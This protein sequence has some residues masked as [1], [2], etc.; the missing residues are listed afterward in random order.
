[1]TGGTP[2]AFTEL[3]QTTATSYADTTVHGLTAYRYVVVAVDASN[4]TSE[5]SVPADV[6][7][8]VEIVFRGS[9]TVLG[10]G[11][12]VSL[13][14]PAAALVGDVLI[15]SIDVRNTPTIG[16]PTGWTLIRS[17]A[18]TFRMTKATYW[19]LVG[20]NDPATYTWTIAP[21]ANATA[22]LL[23]YGGVD[24]TTPIDAHGGDFPNSSRK[25]IKAP[26]ITTTVPGAMLL[27]LYGSASASTYTLPAGMTERASA[28]QQDGGTGGRVS[29]YAADEL[30]PTAGATGDRTA[31]ASVFQ[32]SVGQLIA[33]K[34]AP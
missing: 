15:A 25:L 8:P 29:S 24:G 18:R 28:V 2:G 27:G 33:L 3:G 20:P 23:A 30:R 19:H 11:T 7:T 10:T 32:Y 26:S 34:P 22:V 9:T 13:D 4:N 21:S 5:P 14:R 1:M 17:D 31:T 16:A 12:S 6:T